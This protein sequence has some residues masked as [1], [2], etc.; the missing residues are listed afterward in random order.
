[1]ETIHQ[2]RS[3]VTFKEDPTHSWSVERG[4]APSDIVRMVHQVVDDLLRAAC[5]I[6]KVCG[7]VFS[8]L[9]DRLID[10]WVPVGNFQCPFSVRGRAR[11]HTSIAF[12]IV[13]MKD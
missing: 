8:L 6:K 1:M 4:F 3:V 10:G 9:T 7:R 2:S 13:L 12:S 5:L 11:W